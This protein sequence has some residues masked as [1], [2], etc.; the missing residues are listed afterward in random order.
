[1]CLPST[2]LCLAWASALYRASG[3]A[4]RVVRGAADAMWSA[5][6]GTVRLTGEKRL[7]AETLRQWAASAKA[8]CVRCFSMQFHTFVPV[9]SQ[10]HADPVLA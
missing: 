9:V 5:I 10:C 8:V 1:M 4:K 3:A 2:F 7:A 6:A